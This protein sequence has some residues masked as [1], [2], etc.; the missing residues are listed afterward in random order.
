M[1]RKELQ[2]ELDE[3]IKDEQKKVTG[4]FQIIA[5]MVKKVIIV[6]NHLDRGLG[7]DWRT[8]KNCA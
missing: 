8:R 3:K 5:V 7:L 4:D 1:N 2:N 6:N